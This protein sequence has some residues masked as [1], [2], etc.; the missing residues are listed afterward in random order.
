MPMANAAERSA[1][2]RQGC[3]PWDLAM[4]TD[5]HRKSYCSGSMEEEAGLLWDE[6]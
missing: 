3:F 6:A 5:G 1:K 4:V 2:V